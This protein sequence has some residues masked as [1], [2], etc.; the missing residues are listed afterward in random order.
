MSWQNAPALN[1]LTATQL[2]GPNEGAQLWGVDIKGTLYSTFQTGPGG[3]WSQ[4]RG[5][6]WKEK[7]YPE[8]V[9]ELAAAQLDQDRG[10]LWVLD[11]KRQLWTTTQGS[12]GSPW[13]LWIGP[14]WN[15]FPKG[16]ELKKVAA[17]RL[18][19]DRAA[20][21]WAITDNGILTSCYQQPVAGNWTPFQDW[22]VKTPDNLP[23]I[24]ITACRQGNGAGILWGLDSRM[25][26]WSMSQQKTDQGGPWANAWLGPHWL[27][28]PYLRN[29]AAVDMANG[30]GACIWGITEDY[31]LIYRVQS[32]PGSTEWSPWTS[33]D[34]GD[35]LTGYEITAAGQNN[36]QA[37][38]W[39][40]SLD[41]TLT[42]Q[43]VKAGASA[44]WE[45]Q[46]TPAPK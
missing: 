34:V 35:K 6:D 3:R 10:Q 14:G 29:I 7:T 41:Q 22:K 2:G 42:S 4:W 18:T 5:P 39:V 36:K 12:K 13:G 30:R 32:K 38:V 15:N 25:Q 46:W 27:G 28:A 1:K 33:G 44:D 21:F 17:T 16:I 31:K 43:Q 19:G 11:S 37:R 23:W 9:Y 20:Q 45:R 40:I 8:Q 26:L 24:E